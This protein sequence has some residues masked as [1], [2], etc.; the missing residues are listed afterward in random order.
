MKKNNLFVERFLEYLVAQKNISLNTFESYKSDLL[1]FFRF[2]NNP[3]INE[4]SKLDIN[5]YIIFLSKKFSTNTHSRKLSTIKSFFFFLLEK[6]VLFE[7]PI[8]DYDFPKVRKT[9]PKI[10]SEQE[11]EKLLDFT[12]KDKS[13]KGLRLSLIL[14][15]LYATGIRIS[16]LVSLKLGNIM[17]NQSSLIIIGKGNKE[18]IVPMLKKTTKV[19]RKYLKIRTIFLSEDK[20]ENNFLFPSSSK[21]GHITRNRLFQIL[22]KLALKVDIDPTKISPHT[23]RHS[24]ATHL[25]DR[26]VDLRTIQ[27]SLGHSDISTTQI[28]THVQTSGFKKIL[29]ENRPIKKDILKLIKI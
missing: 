5:N 24:F 13:H 9:I 10:L 22:K 25:L 1:G 19:L 18:R 21:S 17:N 14:E 6:K 7:N 26:G 27:Q 20:K 3:E 4:I 15:I 16:E 8:S 2:L 23:I 29:E 11:I 28:Y 12:Y